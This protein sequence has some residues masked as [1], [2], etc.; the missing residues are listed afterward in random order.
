MYIYRKKDV[1]ET[2]TNVEQKEKQN[3]KQIM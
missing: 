3:G 1:L 2:D